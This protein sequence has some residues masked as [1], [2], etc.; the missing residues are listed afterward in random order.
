MLIA[1]IILSPL[2]RYPENAGH[3]SCYAN[4]D[5]HKKKYLPLEQQKKKAHLVAELYKFAELFDL[6]GDTDHLLRINAYIR[7]YLKQE[8]DNE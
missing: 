1:E 7:E 8:A 5:H 4:S 6:S 3:D 2:S